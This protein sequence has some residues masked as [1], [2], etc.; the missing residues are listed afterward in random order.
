MP[1]K[2]EKLIKLV[3]KEWKLTEPQIDDA[4]VEEEELVCFLESRIS[5][6]EANEVKAHLLHC[7]R[8]M[9]NFALSI[10]LADVQLKEL[11]QDWLLRIKSLNLEEGK[12]AFFEITLQLKDKLLELLSATGD[13]LVG[14]ELIPAPVLRSRNLSEFKDEITLLKD[15]KDIRVEVKVVNKRGGFFNLF[16]M[17]RRKPNQEIIKEL[18]ITLIKGDK[19]LESYLA[20]SGAVTFEHMLLGSYKIELSSPTDKIASVLLTIKV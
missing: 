15:F 6:A 17:A 20:D 8:C 4:H 10:K 16:I 7:N 11:P 18:R 13:V 2:L 19:E 14:Q 12:P 5:E 9:E 3:Y 1:D